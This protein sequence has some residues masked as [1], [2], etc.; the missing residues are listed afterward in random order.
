MARKAKFHLYEFADGVQQIPSSYKAKC[1]ITGE[2]VPIYHKFLEKLIKKHYKN[3]FEYFL[4]HYA[5]KSAAKKKLEDDGYTDDQFSLNAYSD[6]L[7]ICYKACIENLKDN[8]NQEAIV[9]I[10][11][12]MQTIASNFRKHFNRDVTKFV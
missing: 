9:R 11:N 8:F 2:F 10:K 6:Y 4:K 3:N 5:Q 12:E 7:V 1:N